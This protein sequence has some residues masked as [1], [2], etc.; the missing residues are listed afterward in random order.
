MDSNATVGF[1]QENAECPATAM[2]RCIIG[3]LLLDGYGPQ[4]QADAK[5]LGL[6]SSM[7]GPVRGRIYDALQ[8]RWDGAYEV[9]CRLPAADRGEVYRCVRE[10]SIPGAMFR[11]RVANVVKAHVIKEARS[12]SHAVAQSSWSDVD[13]LREA[14]SAKVLDPLAAIS[15]LAGDTDD[16]IGA[17]LLEASSGGD[18]VARLQCAPDFDGFR[19]GRVVV[20]GARPKAGKSVLGLQIASSSAATKPTLLASLEMAR[21][22]QAKRLHKQGGDAVAALQLDIVTHAKAPTIEALHRLAAAKKLRYG[23]LALLVL[24]YV[25][26]ARCEGEKAMKDWERVTK[27]SRECKLI[28]GALDCCVVVLSQLKQSSEGREWPRASDLAQADALQRDADH[29]LLLHRPHM[30]DHDKAKRNEAV[31]IHDISRHGSTGITRLRL[32]TDTLQFVDG[33][34]D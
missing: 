33:Y 15:A 8:D 34:Y 16:S 22:E 18:I 2:E 10:A 26:I 6:T 21:G 5:E 27:I 28:A 24:D 19:R 30:S 17:A 7:L 23:D 3:T 14:V 4:C 9:A 25:Q 29:V 20:I 1:D 31:L 11:S 32:D 13:A 12:G